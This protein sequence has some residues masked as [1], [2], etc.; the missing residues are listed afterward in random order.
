MT[1]VWDCIQ[2]NVNNN[3]VRLHV[4]IDRADNVFMVVYLLG[5]G[6]FA[7]RS[8]V[9]DKTT[10]RHGVPK[11]LQGGDLGSKQKD[12]TG[13]QQDVLENAS[14]CQNQSASGSHQEY[15]SNVEQE[16]DTSVGDENH[17]SN[18]SQ[19][20]EGGKPFG[21]RKNKGVD[22][23]ANRCIVMKRNKG[24][25]FEPVEQELDHNKTR[26]L[27]RNGSGLGDEANKVEVQLSVGGKGDT[28]GNHE[29]DGRKLLARVLNPE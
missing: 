14:K 16:S 2:V 4:R 29:D 26:G 12:R 17:G 27:E 6:S 28:D 13:D 21:E 24:V 19:L 7:S 8:L 1:W 9:Q 15:G 22:E 18:T 3:I 10:K 20:I 23:C 11:D 25:H 5:T